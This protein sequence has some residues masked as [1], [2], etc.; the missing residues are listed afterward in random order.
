MGR[1]AWGVRRACAVASDF[2]SATKVALSEATEVIADDSEL[3]SPPK[4][5]ADTWM[6]N[7]A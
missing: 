4:D 3:S 5:A 7:S 6:V 2:I 1:V